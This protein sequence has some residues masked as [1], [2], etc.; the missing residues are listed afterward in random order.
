MT[1]VVV[2]FLRAQLGSSRNVGSRA[3][4][5]ITAGECQAAAEDKQETIANRLSLW[6]GKHERMIPRGGAGGGGGAVEGLFE[7]ESCCRSPLA[8]VRQQLQQAMQGIPI[9]FQQEQR[10]ADG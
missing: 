9:A 8:Y 7:F 2:A 5:L 1:M 6:R 3:H 4:V 10:E